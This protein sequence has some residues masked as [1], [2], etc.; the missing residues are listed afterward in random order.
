MADL[1]IKDLPELTADDAAEED[2]VLVSDTSSEL[3]KKMGF[4]GFANLLVPAGFIQDFAGP[5][6]P[7]GYLV[8]DGSEVSRATYARLYTAIGDSWGD[9]DGSTTFNLPDLEGMFAVGQ[10]GGDTDFGDVGDTGGE[11]RVTLSLAEMPVHNHPG[12]TNNS[13]DHT[14]QLR[15]AGTTG[16][17]YGLRDALNATSTGM[18]N[19]APA[20]GHTHSVSTD[21]RGSGQSHNNLPPFATVLKV[22][23]F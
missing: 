22:I 6:A 2:F 1:A 12:V 16:G 7:A 4:G 8:C 15:N 14:H 5:A 20:G 10:K 11:K 13:G 17:G 9:G 3:D 23:K 18:L 19:S 21:N